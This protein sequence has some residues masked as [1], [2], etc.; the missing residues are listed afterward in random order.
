M[1]SLPVSF[2]LPYL[3]APKDLEKHWLSK[4]SPQDG[5]VLGIG[6]LSLDPGKGLEVW[7]GHLAQHGVEVTRCPKGSPARVMGPRPVPDTQP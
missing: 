4:S 3:P 5:Q 2:Q 6:I 1:V 7:H